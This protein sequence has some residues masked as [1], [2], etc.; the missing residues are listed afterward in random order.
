MNTSAIM[1]FL[2]TLYEV[3][4]TQHPT[5][6]AVA[7]DTGPSMRSESFVDYKANRE[8]MPD[9]IRASIPYIKIL[10]LLLIFLF[11]PWRVTKLTM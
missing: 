10:S 7:F 2:N 11:M 3:I 9:D 1:G 5:H 6:I 8:E 4:K